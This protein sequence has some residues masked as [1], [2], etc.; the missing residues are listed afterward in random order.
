M[1]TSKKKVVDAIEEIYQEA[2]NKLDNYDVLQKK[3]AHEYLKKL[4][5]DKIQN[6]RQSL[7]SSD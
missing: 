5:D 2:Q 1:D 6:L 4:E 7:M 3:A